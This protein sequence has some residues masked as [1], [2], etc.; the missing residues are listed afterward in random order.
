MADGVVTNAAEFA[1]KERLRFWF[2]NQEIAKKQYDML[3]VKADQCNGCK[4]CMPR[5]PYGIDIVRK[6]AIVDYKLGGQRL[7]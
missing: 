6:M 2:G 3:A 1:L 4:E 5:C 7:F